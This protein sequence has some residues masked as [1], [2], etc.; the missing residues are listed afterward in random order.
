MANVWLSSSPNHQWNPSEKTPATAWEAEIDKEM[1]LQ[2]TSLKDAER[3]TAVDRV[4]QIVAD[5]EPFIYLVYPNALVAISPRVEGAQPA[6]M[7]PGL[8]WNA[9]D[10]RLRGTR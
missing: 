6:V 10:L 2:A 3:K 1:N 9:E 8:W 5:Q 4:Q 7:E